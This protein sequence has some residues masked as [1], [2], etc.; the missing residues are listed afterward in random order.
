ME[1]KQ[2]IK[3]VLSDITMAVIESRKEL[4]DVGGLIAP[5]V[6]SPGRDKISVKLHD[7]FVT[8]NEVEFEVLLTESQREGKQK[9]IGVAFSAINGGVKNEKGGENASHTKIK[10]TIPISFPIPEGREVSRGSDKFIDC[11]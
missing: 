6:N 4:E 5:P 7:G 2:F 3:D 8:T 9:G 1:L 10:F 11:L